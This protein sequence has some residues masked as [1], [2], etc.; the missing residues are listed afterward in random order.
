[1]CHVKVN[2]NLN[3]EGSLV[4]GVALDDP[5][6]VPVLTPARRSAY[7]LDTVIGFLKNFKK[8]PQHSRGAKMKYEQS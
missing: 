2:V 4:E 7:A 1:M 8:I 6:G 5:W 3:A